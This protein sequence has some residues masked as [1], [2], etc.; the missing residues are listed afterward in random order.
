MKKPVVIV[1]ELEY[2]KGLEVF[3]TVDDIEI[4]K[5]SFSEESL[6]DLVREKKAFAVVLG[7]DRYT[8]ALY[9]SL[10]EGGVIARFGVGYD[11]VDLD[12]AR[13]KKLLVTNTPGVLEDAVAEQAVFLAGALLRKI[14]P[15]DRNMRNGKWASELGNE[16]KG[17]VWA[18]IGLG[19]IG[20]KVSRIAS[21][22]FGA[23]VF[24]CEKYAPG[25]LEELKDSC[26]VERISSDYFEV[27][28]CAD[29]L[30]L[31]LPPV[32][33]TRNYIDAEK[34][35]VLK[36]GSIL[37]NNARGALIDEEALYD[38]LEGGNL[39]GAALDVYQKEPYQPVCTTKDLRKLPNVILTPHTASSTK[40]ACRRM[41][42]RVV[43]NIRYAINKEY[44]NMDLVPG[45]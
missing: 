34:T 33:E 43:Q 16:L 23:K 3:R 37:I 44:H 21:F 41:A 26:G 24:A 36:K 8:D 5:S 19:K 38:S 29:I 45:N 10:P 39:A 35:K 25:N 40:E 14:I 7:V 6:A 4:I 17:K 30:S 20:R 31:H 12:R 2:G 9:E 22:G 28:P 1:T 27:A 42:E 18:V 11:G 32:E 13:E 15:L